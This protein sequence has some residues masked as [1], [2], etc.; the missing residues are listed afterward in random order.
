MGINIF[1]FVISEELSID[2]KK[3]KKK[4]KKKKHM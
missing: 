1:L 2:R 3:K 4:K